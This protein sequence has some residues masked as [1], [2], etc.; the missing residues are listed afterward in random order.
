MRKKI[1][2]QIDNVRLLNEKVPGKNLIG[3]TCKIPLIGRE[4]PLL[5]GTF[6]DPNVATGIVMSV[7]DHATDDWIALLEYNE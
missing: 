1:S 4:I 7:P 5:S 2:Y 3:K 6:A